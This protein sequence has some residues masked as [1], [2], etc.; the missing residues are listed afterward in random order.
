MRDLKCKMV[1]ALTFSRLPFAFAWLAFAMAAEYGCGSWAAV[2]AAF[3]LIVSGVTDFFDGTLA[4]RWKVVTP[5]GKLADP[6]M[7]KAVY[8]VVFPALTWLLLRQEG[9]E[10]HSLLM[11]AFTILY[12]L[13]DLWVTFMRSVA[14][15]YGFA[16]GAMWLGKIRTALTFPTAA[17]VYAYVAFARHVCA[18]CGEAL[19]HACY[20]A[21]IAMLALN[22]LSFATYTKVY[23]PYLKKAIESKR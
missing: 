2:A 5:L 8:V 11:L 3:S 10:W 7:D 18:P 13:R 23:A 19:L 22:A 16:P 15:L 21:E 12:T 4:R 1:N 17:L 6:L 9:G 14:S 20:A